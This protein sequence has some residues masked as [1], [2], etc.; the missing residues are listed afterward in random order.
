MYILFA[1]KISA[2]AKVMVSAYTIQ[3]DRSFPSLEKYFTLLLHVENCCSGFFYRSNGLKN[4]VI[5]LFLYIKQYELQKILF[6]SSYQ[7]IYLHFLIKKIKSN[8]NSYKLLKRY[9]N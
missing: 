6:S 1:E 4:C 3:A 8:T 2:K 5:Y 9:T 7:D